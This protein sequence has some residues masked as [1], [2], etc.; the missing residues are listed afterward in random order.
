MNLPRQRETRAQSQVSLT[1]L[2][3]WPAPK[4]FV[5]RSNRKESWSLPCNV[6][7]VAKVDC[8]GLDYIKA[9]GVGELPPQPTLPVG[10]AD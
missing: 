6:K 2:P 3:R 8:Q 9:I 1:T 4:S 5:A 7:P 10:V